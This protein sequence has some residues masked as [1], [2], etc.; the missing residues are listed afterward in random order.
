[1]SSHLR[2]RPSQRCLFGALVSL[3][4]LAPMVC[5]GALAAKFKLLYSF[6]QDGCVA[7]APSAGFV[8]DGQGNL[9]GASIYGGANNDGIVFELE[10][11]G[12][13]R[14]KF[15]L[16]HSFSGYDGIDAR[17]TLVIDAQGNLYGTTLEGGSNNA[18]VVYRLSP[19]AGKGGRRWSEK[20]L[21]N[22]CSAADCKD[23]ANP[24]SGLTYVGA[25]FGSVYDGVSPLYGTTEAGGKAGKGVV[26]EIRPKVTGK[27]ETVIHNMC[28]FADCA[29]GGFP[30]G[31]VVAD[32]AGNLFGTTA[33]GG[34]GHGTIFEL[35]LSPEGGKRRWTETILYNFCGRTCHDGAFPAGDLALDA[36]GNL[37]GVTPEGGDS[38]PGGILNGCGTV[39]RLSRGGNGWIETILHTF[40]LEDDCK[41]G[42]GAFQGVAIDSAGDIFGTT[43]AGGGN[44]IDAFGNGGGVVY[45]ISGSTFRVLHAFCSL[46]DCAD[47]AN[48]FS[49]PIV[50][51]SGY[52]YGTT[53]YGGVSGGNFNG[54]TAFEIKIP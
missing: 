1:M 24:P 15:K 5:G 3:A 37:F 25:A 29:D 39:F 34:E 51:P 49:K 41:D 44:D 21:H 2:G 28:R 43:E 19:N 36:E 40:C 26:F 12:K 27:V 8:R 30:E 53:S 9:F 31:S 10:H 13:H 14:F 35:V 6:C 47:G 18:G 54:G 50:D 38:C 42:I 32:Q 20:V 52:I 33:T 7:R 23:G 4:L 48:P 16:L 17:G 22:F 46:P 45:E 11:I